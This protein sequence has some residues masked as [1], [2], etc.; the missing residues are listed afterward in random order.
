MIVVISV[1]NSPFNFQFT[2]LLDILMQLIE[3][4]FNSDC[5]LDLLMQESDVRRLR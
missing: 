4:K 3:L 2:D 5:E 1:Y